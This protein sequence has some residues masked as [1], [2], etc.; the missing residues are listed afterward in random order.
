MN[1]MVRNVGIKH[2]VVVFSSQSKS[3]HDLEYWKQMELKSY[4]FQVPL[5][6][7]TW[8]PRPT[9][10]QVLLKNVLKSK[11][12]VFL[13]ATHHSSHRIVSGVPGSNFQVGTRPTFPC[14]GP[15]TLQNISRKHSQMLPPCMPTKGPGHM[16]QRKPE[17]TSGSTRDCPLGSTVWKQW[18]LKLQVRRDH[19]TFNSRRIPIRNICLTIPPPIHPPRVNSRKKGLTQISC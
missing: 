18:I 14:L 9:E 1:V 10:G 17:V 19:Y 16:S 13:S 6:G 12:N 5:L 15:I 7:P 11:T 2:N 4:I 3:F 8:M